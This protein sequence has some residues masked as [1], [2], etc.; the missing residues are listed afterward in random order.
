MFPAD[1]VLA[2]PVSSTGSISNAIIQKFLASQFHCVVLCTFL[3]SANS[4]FKTF[5][6]ALH[7]KCFFHI[8]TQTK[9]VVNV[10][11]GEI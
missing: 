8:H 10:C 4:E 5:L 2:H 1:H 9:V 7:S 11:S 3:R 6:D